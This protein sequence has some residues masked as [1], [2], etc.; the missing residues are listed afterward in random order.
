MPSP[1][2]LLI[3]PPFAGIDRPALGVH[4]IQAV[5]RARKIRVDVLYANIFFA[6]SI[7]DVL[8]ENIATFPP[9]QLMGERLFAQVAHGLNSPDLSIINTKAAVA[10]SKLGIVPEEFNQL[11]FDER[12]NAWIEQIITLILKSNYDII[13]VS[14]TFEQTN[15]SILLVMAIRALLPDQI[16]VL[17]GANCEG[18]MGIGLSKLLPEVDHIFSGESEITFADFMSNINLEKK[19][20]RIIVGQP[21]SDLDSLPINDYSSYFDQLSAHL[22]TSNLAASRNIFQTYE[23][24]LVAGGELS[25]TVVF[26]V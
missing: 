17:G 4:V 2:A 25:I 26:V 16:I 8:Y 11:W 5:C 6:A 9:L 24:S 21:N 1:S 23:T 14:S 10:H 13:G 20:D 7:G 18:E 3:V 22:P 19:W 15:P 12:I